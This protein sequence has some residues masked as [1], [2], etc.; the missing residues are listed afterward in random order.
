MR[1][2][3]NKRLPR[4]LKHDFGKYLVIFLFMVMMISLVSGF[5]VADN[6][7][8]HSYDEGFEKYNLEDGHFALDK[9]PDSSLI[10]D[11]E[12]K[13]DSKLYDLRY[14][15]EDEADSGATIRVY[16]DRTEVN[17]ECVM[18]GEMPVSDNEIALDRMYAQ[19]AKI[20]V[21]DTIKLAGKE[22][23]VT[24]FVAVPDYSCLFENPGD[25][26]HRGERP[27]DTGSAR[28]ICR[29]R[30]TFTHPL[31][32]PRAGFRQR[33]RENRTIAVHDIITKQYGY[34]Q[35]ALGQSHLLHFAYTIYRIYIK[36]ASYKTLFQQSLIIP[37]H[38]RAGH[39]PVTGVLGHLPHLFLQGHQREHRIYTAFNIFVAAEAFPAAYSGLL[40]ST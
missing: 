21:G 28:L 24:G 15:E 27:S 29:D 34:L 17:L 6:S 23:K 35:T 30:R 18:E 19:N 4:E 3:L 8:K 16:K 39:I 40:A 2:P 20:K 22:L 31:Q 14:F 13:T 7:V 36:Q 9:E 33:H 1:N 12:D 5:L 38:N 37:R 26:H 32:I 11:I 25:I 10:N